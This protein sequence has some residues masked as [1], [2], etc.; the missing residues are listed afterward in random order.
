VKLT[1]LFNEVA[2]EPRLWAI[3]HVRSA[4]R[5]HVPTL[6]LTACHQ[7]TNASDLVQ[8]VLWEAIAKG[9]PQFGIGGFGEVEHPC[10]RRC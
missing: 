10:C 6:S 5:V 1:N 7:G 3:A 2:Y 9:L 4:E 8:R